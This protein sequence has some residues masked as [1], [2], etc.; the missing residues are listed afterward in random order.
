MNYGTDEYGDVWVDGYCVGNIFIDRNLNVETA[1]KIYL[2]SIEDVVP[3][4]YLTIF[5]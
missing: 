5:A 1:I 4:S 2:K 3:Q